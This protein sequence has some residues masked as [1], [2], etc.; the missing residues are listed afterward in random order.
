MTEPSPNPAGSPL[1]T[2]AQVAER[3]GLAPITLQIW[4]GKGRGPE[5]LRVPGTRLIRYT[6]DSIDRFLAGSPT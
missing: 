4:R 1:L 5:W 6:P 3:L 2:T